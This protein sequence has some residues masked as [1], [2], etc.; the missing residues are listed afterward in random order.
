MSK[1]ALWVL[2][3]ALISKDIYNYTSQF[4]RHS[5]KPSSP[6]PCYDA[7]SAPGLTIY[8][9]T[10][11]LYIHSIPK[12]GMGHITLAGVKHH[13][14]QNFEMWLQSLA[15]GT[16]TPIHSHPAPCEEVNYIMEGRG[17]A[18]YIGQGGKVTVV[19]LRVNSTVIAPPN[20]VW[21]VENNDAK[22]TLKLLVVIGCPVPAIS[23]YKY[24][25]F[26]NYDEQ[27]KATRSTVSPMP[28]NIECP[29]IL[30]V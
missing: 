5:P 6:H 26:L 11:D 22:E 19:D 25:F 23:V 13:G 15:P 4:H 16:V 2:L 12:P 1:T 18:K 3:T 9:A 17:V 20:T 29:P 27:Q 14:L 30:G 8:N 7:Y 28:W 10:T 21:Q 24:D